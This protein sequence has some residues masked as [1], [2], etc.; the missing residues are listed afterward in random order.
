MHLRRERD[1]FRD[2][3]NETEAELEV[4]Y[5]LQDM[6][7]Q[8]KTHETCSPA[9]DGMREALEEIERR[10]GPFLVA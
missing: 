6:S 10:Q 4:L 9:L 7:T 5:T 2:R 1:S 8:G 3:L